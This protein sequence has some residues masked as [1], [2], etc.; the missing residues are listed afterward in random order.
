MTAPKMTFGS[1][2]GELKTVFFTDTLGNGFRD[3]LD[4]L[5]RFLI[6]LSMMLLNIM[7]LR[8]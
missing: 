8:A 6:S 5:R 1:T 2:P 4:I 7:F 3:T